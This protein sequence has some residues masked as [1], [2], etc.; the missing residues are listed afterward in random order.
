MQGCVWKSGL[1]NVYSVEGCTPELPLHGDE[2]TNDFRKIQSVAFRRRHGKKYQYLFGTPVK[3]IVPR[4]K[5]EPYH[6]RSHQAVST[7]WGTCNWKA[8]AVLV[9][10]ITNNLGV[11]DAV[12]SPIVE[13]N[14]PDLAEK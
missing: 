8:I 9:P 5:T 12:R 6:D 2:K 3:S 11:R 14:G 13:A 7:S 4:L 10:R 1:R